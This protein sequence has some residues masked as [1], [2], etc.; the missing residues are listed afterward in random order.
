MVLRSRLSLRSRVSPAAFRAV[1]ILAALLAGCIGGGPRVHEITFPDL[2]GVAPL[3]VELDDR[4]GLVQ[5]VE[6]GAFDAPFPEEDPAAQGLPGDPA[7]IVVRWTG[8]MCD[9]QVNMRLEEIAG[10]LVLTAETER[11]FGGCRL[12]GISRAITLRFRT[13]V[14][15]SRI[16]LRFAD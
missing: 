15:A 9:R 16:D 7:S 3:P 6:L 2:G 12:A 1:L 14:D 8:G 13:P 5:R 4:T 10:V 11:E